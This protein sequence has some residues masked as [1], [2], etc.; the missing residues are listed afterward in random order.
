MYINIES[1]FWCVHHFGARKCNWKYDMDT[2]V[3]GPLAREVSSRRGQDLAR[4]LGPDCR[5]S[6]KMIIWNAEHNRY[7]LQSIQIDKINK[8]LNVQIWNRS[9]FFVG[10][11]INKHH[12]PQNSR[13]GFVRYTRI[14][15]VM[16]IIFL[17]LPNFIGTN[18]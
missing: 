12:N 2:L 14:L 3:Y 15:L 6:I 10:I 17:K 4:A 11:I 13:T 5:V 9:I 1:N 16:V 7:V 8:M 18:I